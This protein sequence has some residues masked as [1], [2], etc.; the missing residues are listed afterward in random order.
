M[1]SHGGHPSQG[2]ICK[3]TA[4]TDWQQED[5][6]DLLEDRQIDQHQRGS[7]HDSVAPGKVQ[8]PFG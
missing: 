3:Q 4:E 2:N 6:L 1:P 5:W 8:N 7:D